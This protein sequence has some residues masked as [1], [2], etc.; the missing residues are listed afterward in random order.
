M[1]ANTIQQSKLRLNCQLNECID[2][3]NEIKLV[4]SI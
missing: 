3:K 2:T 1:Y 4:T